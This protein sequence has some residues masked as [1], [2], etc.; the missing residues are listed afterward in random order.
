MAAVNPSTILRRNQT[1]RIAAQI[2][3][4]SIPN[5]GQFGTTGDLPTSGG[6]VDPP[7]LTSGPPLPPQQPP[8]SDYWTRIDPNM[9]TIPPTV[10]ID[11]GQGS[12]LFPGAGSGSA[13]FPTVGP[14]AAGPFPGGN[15]GGP[16]GSV[17]GRNPMTGNTIYNV[18]GSPRP[19]FFDSRT[20][21]IAA[22][23]GSAALN[24]F[25]PGLGFVSRAIF[26]AARRNQTARNTGTDLSGRTRPGSGTRSTT[27]GGPSTP[28]W[29]Q[30]GYKVP[31]GIQDAIARGDYS[32]AYGPSAASLL[33]S[34]IAA[35]QGYGGNPN[36]SRSFATEGRFLLG[37]G[38][39][40]IQYGP[41]YARNMRQL[42]MRQ[43]IS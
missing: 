28:A 23:L 3:A 22:T 31:Q 42:P 13:Q 29:Y 17:Y 11:P 37:E 43:P 20:G 14:S 26:D 8:A 1:E 35:S 5:V 10:Q 41:Q 19:G 36:N 34:R 40:P 24:V 6:P 16:Q 2:R 12:S 27:G 25:V 32:R 15:M 7:I 21:R 33:S 30:P 38:G 4:G 9:G 18:T 39:I